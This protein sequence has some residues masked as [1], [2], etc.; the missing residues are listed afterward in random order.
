MKT[1]NDKQFFLKQPFIEWLAQGLSYLRIHS[2]VSRVAIALS[3]F[4]LIFFLARVLGLGYSEL[5]AGLFAGSVIGAI[6]TL[7]ITENAIKNRAKLFADVNVIEEDQALKSISSSS[8]LPSLDGLFRNYKDNLIRFADTLKLIGEEAESL[9][10]RYEVLTENLAAAIVIRDENGKITYC[11]PYTEVL[12]GSPLSEIYATHNDFFIQNAH[13][14][15]QDKFRR[16]LSVSSLGEAFQF[17]YRFVHKTGI[18]MWAEMRTVPIFSE[19]S[20]F[21]GTLSITLDITGTMRYQQQ[22]EERNKDLQEFS[23]MISHDLKAPIFTIKGM[24]SVI[25][26][27]HKDILSGEPGELL[28]HIDKAAERLS[29]LVSAV[30]EYS[31]VTTRQS[32][33]EPVHTNAV[34]SEIINEFSPAIKNSGAKIVIQENLPNVIGDKLMVYQIFSNLIGNSLKYRDHTRAL[35]INISA[36]EQT[37]RG[38]VSFIISDTG[39]GISKEK[40]ETI[41]RPFQRAHSGSVEGSGIGLACVK[42]LLQKLGG[43]VT[44]ESQEGSGTQFTIKLP[45]A[46]GT[47]SE[48]R[49]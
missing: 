25:K 16:A 13:E 34:L 3:V 5:T 2:V 45:L 19:N 11:S 15:D 7:N 17:R 10:E 32:N 12:T 28:T 38:A 49:A 6:I 27:D 40:I 46:R 9:I 22:V 14:E 43:S 8:G 35:L 37:N 4:G 48:K 41:F 24:L 30:L 39:L 33:L 20:E 31:K 1:E 36:P 21:L 29:N 18:E 47:L 42:K 26:E 23:Y 44:V